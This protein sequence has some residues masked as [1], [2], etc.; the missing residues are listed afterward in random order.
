MAKTWNRVGGFDFSLFWKIAILVVSRILLTTASSLG[1]PKIICEPLK[2]SKLNPCEFNQSIISCQIPVVISHSQ[3][4]CKIDSFSLLQ[5]LQRGDSK[6]L[7]RNNFEFGANT[8]C[9]ILYWNICYHISWLQVFGSIN[10]LFQK[11]SS[12]RAKSSF[13]HLHTAERVSVFFNTNCFLTNWLHLL[14]PNMVNMC[15]WH[16]GPIT[17]SSNSL[18]KIISSCG[19]DL[20]KRI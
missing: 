14:S 19:I 4:R 10:I 7:Y 17:S 5:K 15:F 3:K 18:T 11:D 1:S 6:I 12:S 20:I 8:R 16:Q 9:K 2:Y 13:F